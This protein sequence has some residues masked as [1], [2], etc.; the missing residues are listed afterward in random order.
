MS[1]CTPFPVLNSWVGLVPAVWNSSGQTTSHAEKKGQQRASWE[2]N[3]VLWTLSSSRERYPVVRAWERRGFKAMDSNS[4]FMQGE[5]EQRG[6]VGCSLFLCI[7]CH[8]PREMK[9]VNNKDFQAWW[10]GSKLLFCLHRPIHPTDPVLWVH[11]LNFLHGLSS[12]SAPLATRAI[13]LGHMDYGPLLTNVHQEPSTALGV[14]SK[15]LTLA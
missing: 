1:I 9:A 15:P 4:L 12:P 7:V 8:L 13:L 10:L 6:E 5:V 2:Y 14:K 3:G 11:G